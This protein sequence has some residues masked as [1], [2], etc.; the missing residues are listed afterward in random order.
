MEYL[1]VLKLE[2]EKWYIG[3]SANVERRY[4][5]H[6]AGTGAKWTQLHKPLRVVIKRLLKDEQDEDRTTQAFIKKYGANN[7]RGG[8]YCQVEPKRKHKQTAVIQWSNYSQ[9]NESESGEC[10]R[11][12]R[13]SHW[14]QD[15]YATYDVDGDIIVSDSD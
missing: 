3:R 7:V 5:Q 14:Q 13:M 11:C 15:C 8:S 12:G 10:F 4:E 9:L 1:Y 2:K 6:L